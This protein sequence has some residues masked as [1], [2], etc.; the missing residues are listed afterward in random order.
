MPN[1]PLDDAAGAYIT[2]LESLE[3][4]YLRARANDVRDMKARILRC[5]LG[6]ME[7]PLEG[8]TNPHIL[9]A[10]DLNPSDTATLDK[11]L[12]LGFCTAQG[13]ATS[14]AAILARSMGLP[15]VAGLGLDIL[16]TAD[17]ETAILDGSQGILYIDPD[18]A[19]MKA[20][21]QRKQSASSQLEQ[22]R[23]STHEPAVTRDGLHVDVF[24]NIGSVEDAT[25]AIESGAEGV[26]LLRT[27]F[28]Y[29]QSNHLPTEE[30]QYQTYHQILEIFGNKPVILRTLDIGGDKSLP[31]FD[32]PKEDNPFLGQRGIRLCLARPELIKPQLRA[33]LRAG[34]GHNLKIMF[35][36]IADVAEVRSARELIEQ[37]RAELIIE[38]VM[39][40]DKVDIGIMVEIPAAA[41]NA[42]ALAREVDFF[43]IGTNDLSQYTL[44]ADRTNSSVA[45]LASAFHP[46][47]LRLIQMVIAA[48]HKQGK[49]VGLCGELAGEPDAAPI[50]L[51]FGLDEFSMSAPS[52]PLVKAMLRSLNTVDAEQLAEAVLLA[53][54]PAAVRSLVRER[55]DNLLVK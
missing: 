9:M 40:S 53:A 24:A 10:E 50:L 22:A 11:T 46:S 3:D 6:A 44:A 41:L 7:T 32:L 17:S 20:A 34:Q 31:Y 54:D 27:E 28:L 43:S 42:D 49:M 21:L 36:M 14:H 13:G 2:T 4:D 29:M 55:L 8:L 35:P 45:G 26:G 38:K 23:A 33:A 47:V 37:C 15:A 18:E 1:L 5:L 52:I 30:E 25:A 19:V 39:I 51:G 48:A 16:T 12:V